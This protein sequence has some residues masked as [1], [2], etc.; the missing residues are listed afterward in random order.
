MKAITT[1]YLGPTE[2]RGARIRASEGDGRSVTVPWDYSLDTEANHIAAARELCV[3][4]GWAGALASGW[5]LGGTYVHTFAPSGIAAFDA[6]GTTDYP[7]FAD[8]KPA[9]A[10]EPYVVGR[11]RACGTLKSFPE[12]MWREHTGRFPHG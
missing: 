11:C 5:Q 2:T 8:R 9:G 1:R 6:L 7:P 4:M 3:R 12:S 10:I